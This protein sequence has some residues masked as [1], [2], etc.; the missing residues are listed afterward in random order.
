MF[1]RCTAK[2]VE[3]HRTPRR[4]ASSGAYSLFTNLVS[5]RKQVMKNEKPSRPQP[6]TM[7]PP[8]ALNDGC[9]GLP[10]FSSWPKVYWLVAAS[11]VLWVMFLLALTKIFA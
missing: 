6:C 11:F 5:L 7:P 4:F 9:T 1:G 2:A 8:S 3:G 10:G